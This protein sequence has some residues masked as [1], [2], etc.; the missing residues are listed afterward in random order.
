MSTLRQAQGD[1]YC[2]LRD[3]QQTLWKKKFTDNLKASFIDR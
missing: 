1:I 3:N 2:V